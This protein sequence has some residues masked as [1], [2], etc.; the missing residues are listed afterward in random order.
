M[1]E[2]LIMLLFRIGIIVIPCSALAFVTGYMYGYGKG[3]NADIALKKAIDDSFDLQ[4]ETIVTM[5][6][7]E[8]VKLSTRKRR[9]KNE[10]A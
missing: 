1:S 4:H 5:P 7:E 2:E 6:S 3:Y 9:A 8:P 10:S